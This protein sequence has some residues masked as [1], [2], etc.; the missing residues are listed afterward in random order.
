MKR[1]AELEDRLEKVHEDLSRERAESERLRSRLKHILWDYLPKQRNVTDIPPVDSKALFFD[2]DSEIRFRDYN[3][4]SYI[5]RGHFGKV[6]CGSHKISN[7]R[8]A[9]K[10]M[11]LGQQLRLEDVLAIEQE[12]RAIKVLTHP[13]CVRLVQLI[14]G[15]EHICIVMN[16][17]SGG[18]L[19]DYITCHHP[20]PKR[21]IHKVFS[22][23][24]AAVAYMHQRGF[25]HRD[26]KPENVLVD[27]E[28]EP[29]VIDFGLCTKTNPGAT[30]KSVCGTNGFMAPELNGQR[31]FNPQ[32]ADMWSAGCTLAECAFGKNIVGPLE[33]ISPFTAPTVLRFFFGSL[34]NEGGVT[35]R[36]DAALD[37]MTKTLCEDPKKRLPA[38]KAAE[39]SIAR[40]ENGAPASSGSP[41][42]R[43]SLRRAQSMR[44][45]GSSPSH[46]AISPSEF[47]KQNALHMDSDAAA[48][49]PDT[50]P[51]GGSANARTP[52]NRRLLLSPKSS[53]DEREFFGSATSSPK[54]TSSLADLK[55]HFGGLPDIS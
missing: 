40:R 23:I 34:R 31:P 53:A 25:S 22:G 1:I 21:E 26:L 55:A 6:Y 4:V 24:M 42:T 11:E 54:Q 44:N 18:N 10:V 47:R 41:E 30:I 5:G 50:P 46:A 39:H 45:M 17:V 51:S 38:A 37:F 14:H 49:E 52:S 28:L 16:Y 3:V 7:E 33:D 13:N 32:P 19:H 20:I 29:V 43:K 2:D 48:R 36:T 12:I 8:V 15:K 9:I 27:S 35:D